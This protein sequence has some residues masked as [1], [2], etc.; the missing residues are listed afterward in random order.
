M[1]KRSNFY[2][3]ALALLATMAS[4]GQTSK[5]TI[6]GTV[7]D[8]S[9][10]AVVGA[11]VTAKNVLGAD[12]RSVKTGTAGEYR[13]DAVTP[14]E[15]YTMTVSAAG[16]SNQQV[17]HLIV[18]GSVVTSLNLTV[19]IGGM[20]QTVSVEASMARLQTDSAELSGSVSQREIAEL[21]IPGLNPTF[22]VMLQPGT[23][24]VDNGRD[25]MTN[26]VGFA[27]DGLRPRGNNY[28]ID[29]FDNNDAGIAGQALQPSNP[30]AVR[31]VVSLRNS[32]PAE[33]GR[34]GSSLTNVLY[35]N[36]TNE[37]HGAMWDRY[38]GSGLDALTSEQGRA[39]Y[40]SVPRLVDN[41]F[42][43]TVGG[44]IIKNKLFFFGSS[45]WDHTNGSETGNQLTVPT[46]NG[47]ATLQTLA[48][49]NSNAAILVNSLAGFTASD[50]TGTLNIGNRAGCVQPCMIEVGAGIRTPTQIARS[51]EYVVRGDYTPTESDTLSARFIGTRNSLTPDL[52]ANAS[53]LATQDTQQGGPAR[54]LGAFW[55][56]IISPSKVNELR[57]TAQQINFAF[58]P[59]DSTTSNALYKLPSIS[60][61]GFSGTTFGGL[62][63]TF[64]Q[65]RGHDTYQFQDA[66]SLTLGK[67]SIKI[68]ADLSNLQINDA[69]PFNSRG[70]LAVAAGG[71]CSGIGLTKCTGL[72]NF[73]DNF[74]GPA[75]SAGKQFGSQY[76]GFAQTT[77]A[78]YFQDSWRLRA[79]LSVNY[80][81]R[82]EDYATPFN[83]L[84]YPTVNLGSVLTDPV[85]TRVLQQSSKANWGPRVG[86]AYTPDFGRSIFGE[87][88]TVIRVGGGVFYD[89]FFTNI[90]DNTA[91]TSPN[92]LGGTTTAAK[93][94]R[95]TANALSLVS[96]ITA[97]VNPLAAVTTAASNLRNPRIYQWNVNVERQLPWNMLT[98]IA[99][100]GTRGQGLFLNQD[101]NPG[102]DGVRLNPSRGS[103]AV[104]TNIG[105][106]SYNGLQVGLERS[107]KSGFLARVA[108][109]YSKAID[110]GSEIFTST[111]GSS[112]AQNAFDRRSERGVA[113]FD[114]PHRGAVTLLYTTPFKGGANAAMKVVNYA[115][116]HWT[117]S[118]TLQIQSGAPDTI[119]MYGYDQNGDLRA[120]NDRPSLLSPHAP[121]NYSDACV[122]SPTCITGVGQYQANGSLVDWTTGAS[123]NASQFRYAVLSSGSGNV[124]RN[125]FRND[126]SQDYSMAV[127]RI[128]T[129]PRY[130][131]QQFEVRAEGFNPFNHPNPGLVSTDISDPNFM[132]AGVAR[133]GGRTVDLWLKYRF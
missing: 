49:S 16:F 15:N 45:Q 69:I 91:S 89:P 92:A 7:T 42:G 127:S 78:Y 130:E 28:L 122:S 133:T 94:G 114:R 30:E 98:T 26:S 61:P 22:L 126:W 9:G 73:L 59:L 99:Y 64:P 87:N 55:T 23:V 57:F 63:A 80:G 71:D 100:V 77:Q 104:R 123:G 3:L 84:P 119:Y 95:G 27:V 39:G 90:A 36:G 118:G 83:S 20:S 65:G 17:D 44:P 68:G 40:T 8:R 54:N 115:A 60:I 11:T 81:V 117:L 53:A 13:I 4:W 96:G 103:I 25:N 74:T 58:S 129:I 32:Y 107:F 43:F 79:N 128:F 18:N 112:Y 102:V 46:A 109:T 37:L 38:T 116:G 41:T 72:A 131:K 50:A 85:N 110:N 19:E 97:V 121:I 29:G 24:N 1:H 52:F 113:G 106:S 21:P 10:G 66:L 56:H 31:E 62:S 86:L 76:L 120:T 6:S 93:L 105:D 111:G 101:L 47:L 132:N 125:T 51:Y 33:F 12:A 124:G 14:S 75:G 2:L 67:H 48:Q 34:G 70:T 35:K 108:Y 82:W 5:G 88:K